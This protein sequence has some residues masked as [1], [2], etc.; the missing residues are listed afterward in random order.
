M[1]TTGREGKMTNST[2]VDL[3]SETKIQAML[4]F[5]IGILIVGFAGN[6]LVMAVTTGKKKKRSVYDLFILNLAI[7]DFSFVVFTMPINIV[8]T[9]NGLY[10]TLHY[11]RIVKPLLTIVYFLSIFSITSMA[12]HRCTLITNPRKIKMKSV[13]I[14]ITLIWVLSFLIVL[15]LSIVANAENGNCKEEWPSLNHQ[16]AYTVA[17]FLMQFVFPLFIIAVAYFRIGTYLWRTTVP[18][19]SLS[20]SKKKK[21]R[22][23]RQKNIK[24]IKTLALIVILF[25][26]CLLPGQIA[27]LL[28]DFGSARGLKVSTILFHFSDILDSLHGCVNP[29]IYGLLTEQ[30]RRKYVQYFSYCFT[31]GR[32]R[33]L[34]ELKPK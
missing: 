7:S 33:H 5:Y 27:W 24:V 11:C 1:N 28:L 21:A 10:K 12:V 4:A 20:D 6:S 17:L 25:V 8:L 34:R 13:Y 14:W 22:R 9:V 30:F 31:C 26:I 32:Q 23:R 19:S 15:P 16:K 2:D 29:I 3:P 18:D